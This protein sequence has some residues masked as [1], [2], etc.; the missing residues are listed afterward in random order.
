MYVYIYIYKYISAPLR[1]DLFGSP[2]MWLGRVVRAHRVKNPGS[3]NSGA[4][5]I[6]GD[7]C[8]LQVRIGLGLTLTYPDYYFVM[9]T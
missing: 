6:L 5:L 9:W 4:S 8:T 1:V 7:I 2:A 3:R